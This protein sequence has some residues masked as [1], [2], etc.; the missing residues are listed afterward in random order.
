MAEGGEGSFEDPGDSVE[1]EGKEEEEGYEDEGVAEEEDGRFEDAG[2][3]EEGMFEGGGE[4]KREVCPW[5][6]KPV[7]GVERRSGCFGC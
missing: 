4:V 3:V 6:L 7:L 2:G 1:D 5:D